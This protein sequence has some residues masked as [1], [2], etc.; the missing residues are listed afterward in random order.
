MVDSNNPFD[1]LK[2]E[3]ENDDVLYNFNLDPNQS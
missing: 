3:M 2:E 1:L